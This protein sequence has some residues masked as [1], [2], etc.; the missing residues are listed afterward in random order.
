MPLF[1]LAPKPAALMP[2]G[3][4]SAAGSDV[5]T[6]GAV[7]FSALTVSA[8]VVV[9]SMACSFDGVPAGSVDMGVYDSTGSNGG[10]G[11]RLGHTGAIAATTGLFVQNLTA[12]LLLVPGDYWI[13]FTDTN[14]ADTVWQRQ[15]GYAGQVPINRSNA[16]GLTALPQPAGAF[17][18]TTRIIS[19]IAYLQG[20]F[21]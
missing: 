12:N 16:T 9:T 10:P 17:A 15:A 11:N 18:H 4:A 8:P 20:S 21:T 5:T 6:A 13:A 2:D 7:Y 19:L 14:G 3:A 1:N